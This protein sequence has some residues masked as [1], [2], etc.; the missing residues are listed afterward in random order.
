[1]EE[2][3]AGA[4]KG[5][6]GVSGGRTVTRDSIRE[7]ASGDGGGWGGWFKCCSNDLIRY[8][9]FCLESGDPPVNQPT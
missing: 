7:L 3:D 5:L 9:E 2:E 4:G 8:G 6:K 1:M